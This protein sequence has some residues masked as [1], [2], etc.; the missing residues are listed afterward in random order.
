MSFLLVLFVR[1]IAINVV[2]VSFQFKEIAPSGLIAMKKFYTIMLELPSSTVSINNQ[3]GIMGNFDINNWKLLG[4]ITE[5]YLRPLTL[6]YFLSCEL[7]AR[8]AHFS[9][10][11]YFYTPWKRRK[12][13]GFLTFSGC[14]EMSHWA[15]MLLF[16][17]RVSVFTHNTSL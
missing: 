10:I 3:Q 11:F 5:L 12:T 2:V 14:I 7:W 13:K 4:N 8:V 9:P 17:Y 1:V 6:W 16:F 15:K